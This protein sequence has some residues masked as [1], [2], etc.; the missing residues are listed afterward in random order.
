M[1]RQWKQFLLALS[2]MIGASAVALPAHA[3]TNFIW[4][5]STSGTDAAAEKTLREFMIKEGIANDATIDSDRLAGVVYDKAVEIGCFN[6]I[7]E[8]GK[9]EFQKA[10]LAEWKTGFRK[11]YQLTAARVPWTSFMR[12][13]GN[14]GGFEICNPTD[15]KL[16]VQN[17]QAQVSVQTLAN[18]AQQIAAKPMSTEDAAKHKAIM[19]AIEEL[20]AQMAGN[21]A[22]VGRHEVMIAELN[23]QLAALSGEVGTLKTE[24]AGRLDKLETGLAQ[25]TTSTDAHAQTLQTLAS[26]PGQV[27][28]VEKI[29]KANS[30]VINGVP[31]GEVG[32][33]GVISKLQEAISSNTAWTFGGIGLLV[34]ILLLLGA[35]TIWP[36]DRVKKP[37]SMAMGNGKGFGGGNNTGAQSANSVLEPVGK[38]DT[39]K[40]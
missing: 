4:R 1:Q 16:I 8:L 29:S 39:T 37:S 18:Q 9:P 7:S 21:T 38:P 35:R 3:N 2:F 34:V 33:I 12:I 5:K 17:V 24:V 10:F 14:F 32:L 26:L 19:D 36:P 23:K 31:D 15:V 20:K 30:R 40:T 28:E 22:A 6:S 11:K 25:V 27:A 13:G